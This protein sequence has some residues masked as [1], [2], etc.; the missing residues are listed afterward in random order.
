VFLTGY[1]SKNRQ[2]N[3]VYYKVTT[4]AKL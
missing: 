2:D 3:M 4:A 1:V